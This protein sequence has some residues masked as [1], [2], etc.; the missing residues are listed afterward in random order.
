[1]CTPQLA[2]AQ[3]M[4]ADVVLLGR[5]CRIRLVLERPREKDEAE[6]ALEAVQT[7]C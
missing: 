4:Q 7:T 6:V 3:H 5:A 2:A 1:V